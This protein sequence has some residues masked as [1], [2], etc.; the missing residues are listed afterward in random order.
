MHQQNRLRRT[1]RCIIFG[2]VSTSEALQEFFN[3][4]WNRHGT[5]LSLGSPEEKWSMPMRL[6]A[7]DLGWVYVFQNAYWNALINIYTFRFVALRPDHSNGIFPRRSVSGL[8]HQ[9]WHGRREGNEEAGWGQT[10]NMVSIAWFAALASR[11][12]S[13]PPPIGSHN[14]S[15]AI[16]RLHHKRM[17]LDSPAASKQCRGFCLA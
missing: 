4:H 5:A 15:D 3:C 12:F 8:S 17:D 14:P 16:Q 1:P 9:Q 2:L 13:E 10:R 6:G 11:A 7:V